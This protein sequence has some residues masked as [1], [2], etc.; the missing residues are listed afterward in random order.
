VF[1]GTAASENIINAVMNFRKIVSSG[2]A[3]VMGQ[4]GRSKPLILEVKIVI[5][6][7][8]G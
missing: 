4:N 2:C 5:S 8:P 6:I 1:V 7:F 3:G